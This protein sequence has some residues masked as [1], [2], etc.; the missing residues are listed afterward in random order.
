MSLIKNLT[1]YF[2]ENSVVADE[3][4]DGNLNGYKHWKTG[5]YITTEFEQ[6]AEGY[7]IS[8]EQ[9]DHYG[10]EGQGTN[11]FNVYKFTGQG[12]EVFLKFYGSYHSYDGSY[13]EGFR[14]VHPKTK[15]VVVY[16]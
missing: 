10:G 1:G 2:N 8:A 11:Y 5:D 15:T 3:A 13:Y 4:F 12:E 16:E 6:W 9:V 7:G 14:Q